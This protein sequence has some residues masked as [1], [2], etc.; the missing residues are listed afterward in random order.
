ML[1]INRHYLSAMLLIFGLFTLWIRCESQDLRKY[2]R[3]SITSIGAVLYKT[4]PDKN[5]TDM[6]VNRMK[7]HLEIPRFDYNEI[8]STAVQDFVTKART[9]DL[10]PEKISESL[11]QTIV[12]QITQ[13]LSAVAEIRARGN[14]KEEDLARAAV[15]KM[16]GSGLTADDILKVMNS[17][18]LYLPVVTEYSETPSGNTLKSNI[19]GYILWYKINVGSDL[20]AKTI[21]L[22]DASTLQ[23]GM[24]DGDINKSYKLKKREVG[25][26]D[27]ARLIAINTWVKNLAV[28]M[29]NISDFKL[30]AEVK[31]VE[32][33]NV[34]AG[35][36]DKEGLGLDD[37]YNIVEFE[38]DDSGNVKIQERGFYRVDK[39]GNN[40][41]S[42]T[43]LSTFHKYLGGTPERGMIIMERPRLGIDITVRP[44]FFT[45]KIPRYA[46]PKNLGFVSYENPEDFNNI[47]EHGFILSEDAKSGMGIDIN[48][49]GNIAK[50]T[51]VRQLFLN[52][53]I[54]LGFPNASIDADALSGASIAPLIISG[55]LGPMKK[56]WFG[57]SNLN[58][59]A[60]GGI[61]ILRLTNTGAKKGDLDNISLYSPGVKINAGF[62][63]LLSSDLSIGIDAGY[64]IGLS[65]LAATL[66]IKDGQ[67][68]DLTT[69][70][71]GNTLVVESDY[72]KDLNF[73]GLNISAG[74]SYALPSL[75]FDPFAFLSAKT[76]D[77]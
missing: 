12:P 2:Q 23:E 47:D 35:L 17:A 65:P 57:S 30:S 40:F 33:S 70:T 53:D 46:T 39:I 36:G 11:D 73:S 74:V 37:G 54:A 51:G 6:V 56:L 10:S 29:K 38:Q 8:S 4:M 41:E 67:E 16:K 9:T 48:F 66:A 77:Y 72:F 71:I 34:L 68:Y 55:Y 22:K 61:D 15:D 27:Y 21:L 25:G 59:S 18:Y 3:K 62:E 28:A 19:K 64:K 31:E 45:A 13:A 7:F 58:L 49:N 14:Q 42:A 32:G 63:F 50:L 76:I 24:G 5:V 52:V 26:G 43:N 60:S 69:E 44:K 1:Q 20:L 75:P